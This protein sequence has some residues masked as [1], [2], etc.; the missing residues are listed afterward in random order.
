MFLPS[1]DPCATAQ[2][3]E[4]LDSEQPSSCACSPQYLVAQ[5]SAAANAAGAAFA[6][7]NALPRF[8]QTAY[9]T[10]EAAARAHVGN[11]R[12]FYYLRLGDQLLQ[13]N[14][15]QTF[16]GFVNTMHNL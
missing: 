1:R 4:M 16:A 13:Q 7:E 5:V 2:C 9:N 6:G 12:G 3:L 10:V 8:D 14:N 15:L 11:F